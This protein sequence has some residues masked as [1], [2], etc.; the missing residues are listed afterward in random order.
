MM[1]LGYDILVALCEAS[2][3]YQGTYTEDLDGIHIELVSSEGRGIRYT[4]PRSDFRKDSRIHSEHVA[5]QIRRMVAV[6][7]IGGGRRR[8][9]Q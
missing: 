1:K 5:C 4:I 2:S 6:L 7:D 3:R 9:E 8:Y